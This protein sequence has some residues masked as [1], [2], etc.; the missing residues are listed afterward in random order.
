MVL[1]MVQFALRY[2]FNHVFLKEMGV[3]SLFK[4]LRRRAI[5]MPTFLNMLETSHKTEGSRD[6][7]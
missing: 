1:P 6:R 2:Y 5:M 7:K 3:V 4:A